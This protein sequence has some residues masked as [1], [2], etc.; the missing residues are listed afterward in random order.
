MSRYKVERNTAGGGIEGDHLIKRVRLRCPE[1]L[2][3]PTNS[4]GDVEEADTPLQERRHG[5]LISRIQNG[6]GAATCLQGFPGEA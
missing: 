1:L 2:Q 3:D 4:L 6:G 5:N